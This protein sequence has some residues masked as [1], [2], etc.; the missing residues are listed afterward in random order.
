[1][2]LLLLLYTYLP[3]FWQLLVVSV[4]LE[5]L[6]LSLKLMYHFFS[7]DSSVQLIIIC[8]KKTIERFFEDALK[9]N[10]K[11]RKNVCFFVNSYRCQT[12]HHRTQPHSSV[13]VLA[14]KY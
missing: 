5:M 10:I 3:L 12:D 11:N 1:M 7:T 2:S 14:R 13:N 8:E 9:D 4:F 6:F